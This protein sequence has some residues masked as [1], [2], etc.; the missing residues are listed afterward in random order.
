[1]LP[2]KKKVTGLLTCTAYNSTI[3]LLIWLPL[4]YQV[5]IKSCQLITNKVDKKRKKILTTE[6]N[7]ISVLL[8]WCRFKNE[9]KNMTDCR[10]IISTFSILWN[11]NLGSV[12]TIV[13]CFTLTILQL[14]LRSWSVYISDSKHELYEKAWILHTRPPGCPMT[15]KGLWVQGVIAPPTKKQKREGALA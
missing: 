3:E 11:E 6:I 2:L 15:E 7:L 12:M 9:R 4:S 8:F 13:V 1:M 5:I 10:G 14:L